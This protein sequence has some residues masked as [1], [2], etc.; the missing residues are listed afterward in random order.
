MLPLTSRER[1]E[2]MLL[3]MCVA[4]PGIGADYL[5]ELSPEHLSTDVVVRARDWLL[6]H[7]DRPIEGLPRDDEELVSPI[8]QVVMLAKREPAG[9]EALELN[10]LQLEIARVEREIGAA[11]RSGGDPPVELLQLHA[12]LGDRLAGR[13]RRLAGRAS[14]SGGSQG[15]RPVHC[16]A[17]FRGGEIGS[18]A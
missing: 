7:L 16:L 4:S 15:A 13:A 5:R 1:R 10:F 8:S 6:G 3:A 11:T 18:R 14:V 9:E 2:R 12:E 17:A